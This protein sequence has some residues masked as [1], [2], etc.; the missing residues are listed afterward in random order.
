MPDRHSTTV[1]E[2]EEKQKLAAAE[3]DCDVAF[4]GGIIPG[5]EAELG[6]LLKAGVKGF[7]CTLTT[8]DPSFPAVTEDD[9]RRACDV[10]PENTLVIFHAELGDS[11]PLGET[12]YGQ[13]QIIVSIAF[14]LFTAEIVKRVTPNPFA[15]YGTVWATAV[16]TVFF[17]FASSQPTPTMAFRGIDVSTWLAIGLSTPL[18]GMALFDFATSEPKEGVMKLAAI[19]I[20]IAMAAGFIKANEFS[21]L[22]YSNY[23]RTRPTTLEDDAMALILRV[24]KAYPSLRF[25]VSPLSSTTALAA[26]R[27]A[28][29]SVPNLTLS[30]SPHYLTF[31]D[32]ALPPKAFGDSFAVKSIKTHPPIRDAEN[33]DHLSQALADGEIT[34]VVS[35]HSPA[36]PKQKGGDYL[37]SLGGI[38]SLGLTLPLLN[39]LGLPLPRIVDWM[40]VKQAI[41]A[42]LQGHKGEIRVGADADFVVFDPAAESVITESSLLFKHKHSPYLGKTVRGRVEATYLRGAKVFDTYG[43]AVEQNK[44]Q[45]I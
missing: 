9:I 39:T 41:E 36:T 23:L 12:P 15:F 27:E 34:S 21:P 8:F 45:V 19:G 31:H 25:H 29:D 26:F 14:G 38:S 18:A 6:P 43:G 42:G 11:I 37:T 40:G 5:N 13:L 20:V 32:Q 22:K 3:A 2:L 24:A 30:T 1:A 17:G 35:S 28:R 44:G 16:L 33:R 10:L 7:K 4:W